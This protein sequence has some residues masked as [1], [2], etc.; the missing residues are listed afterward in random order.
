MDIND[1]IKAMLTENTGK[2]MCDSGGT[3]GRHWQ[4]NQETNFNNEPEIWFDPIH[5]NYTDSESICFTV[6][7]Y[8]YLTSGILELDDL[9][10]EF[11]TLPVD[12][13]N[14]DYYGTSEVGSCWIDS[15]E[16]E[17]TPVGE[18]FNTYNGE[19]FLSQT[20]QGQMFEH[21][22]DSKYLLLQ[23][24]QG[25]DVRGGYTDAKLFK[26]NSW[27]EHI[28]PC[29]SVYGTIDG[30]E[31]GTGYNGWS[32]TTENGQPVPVNMESEVNLTVCMD[33]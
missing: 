25:A 4:R 16:R 26:L 19:C 14:G 24:H 18:A 27:I 20:L 17:L 5:E 12:D 29:P 15:L 30:V 3:D 23:I 1:T 11:N 28:N 6:S 31:V 32:L 22:D 10:S 2:A 33:I 9:C 8:K 13:W 21:G 7:V